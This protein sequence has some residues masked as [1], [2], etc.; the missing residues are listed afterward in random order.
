MRIEKN[1]IIADEGMLI[2][3]IGQGEGFKRCLLL[4]NETERDF[5]EA[6]SFPEEDD[7]TRP[8][9]EQ[10]FA[11]FAKMMVAPRTDM[12]DEQV[13]AMPD[14]F[15]E[16]AE[17]IGKEVPQGMVLNYGGK[18]W[19]V[20]KEHLVQAI[21]PPSTDTGSLYAKV[22]RKNAGT[23]EDPIPYEQM[24]ILEKGKYYTQFGVTY[25][26]IQSTNTGFPSDLKDMSSVVTPLA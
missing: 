16:W 13:L 11:A 15:D 3:R 21:F 2:R 5:E 7:T 23:I 19:R 20:I 17:H 6:E 22:N 24:M 10:Q 14:L 12:T 25:L 4:P 26:C 8:T 18:Q 1:E 9:Q